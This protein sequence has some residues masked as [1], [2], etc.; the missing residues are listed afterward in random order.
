MLPEILFCRPVRIPRLAFLGL[1]TLFCCLTLRGAWLVADPQVITNCIPPGLGATTLSWDSGG[2]SPVQIRVNGVDGPPITGWSS[3]T[4]TAQTGEWVGEGTTF[5]LVDSEGNKLARATPQMACGARP[6]LAPEALRQS[7]F[8]L[9]VGNQWVYQVSNRGVTSG[10][11]QWHVTGTTEVDG[12]TYYVVTVPGLDISYSNT[13]PIQRW[14]RTDAEGNIY[15]RSPDGPEQL[16]LDPTGLQN[17]A[18]LLDVT[19][20]DVALASRLGVLEGAIRFRQPGSSMLLGNGTIAPGVGLVQRESRMMAGSSGGFFESFELVYARI[21]D[22][23]VMTAPELA[24]TLAAEASVLRVGEGEVTN[25]T[26]PCYFAA[27]GFLPQQVDPPGTY[28]PCFRSRITL[29]NNTNTPV[30]LTLPSSQ[31]YEL[32]LADAQ[33]TVVY[34]HS[35]DKIFPPWLMDVVFPPGETNYFEQVPLY[36]EPN[37][38]FPPGRYRLTATI[39]AVDGPGFSASVDL[40]IE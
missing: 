29:R 12:V 13:G 2:I 14:F 17:D 33:G 20:T 3:A 19:A 39:E 25:C 18:A 28:K 40:S 23:T 11:T 32:E 21:G 4:G 35:R 16:W 26:V 15:V 7:F 5:S 1:L 38:P 10:Y 24:F 30:Q 34:R 8:P 6:A 31:L 27:C 9:Q 22:T 36:S 37:Q